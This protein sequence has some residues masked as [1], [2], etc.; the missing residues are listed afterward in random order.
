[1]VY[2]V[3]EKGLGLMY[4]WSPLQAGGLTAQATIQTLSAIYMVLGLFCF[5][6]FSQ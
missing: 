2:D 1:M 4:G 5:C 6:F 3:T